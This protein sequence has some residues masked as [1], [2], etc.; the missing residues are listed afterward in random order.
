[1]INSCFNIVN[2]VFDSSFLVHEFLEF[3]LFS[4]IGSMS[5][6]SCSKLVNFNFLV[7]PLLVFVFFIILDN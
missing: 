2:L 5:L 6:F 1:M 4:L 7:D 3:K